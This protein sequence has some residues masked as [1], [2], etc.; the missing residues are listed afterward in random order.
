M[1]VDRILCRER[2]GWARVVVILQLTVN[3]LIKV[4]AN[5]KGWMERTRT[6]P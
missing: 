2:I 5:F 1:I 6:P 3:G 4:H